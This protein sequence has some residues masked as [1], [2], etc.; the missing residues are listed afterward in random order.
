MPSLLKCPDKLPEELISLVEQFGR[1]WAASSERPKPAPYVLNHWSKLLDEWVNNSELP[2]FVRKSSSVRGSAVEH[3]TGREIVHCDNSPAHWA[4]VLA[5]NGECPSIKDIESWIRSDSI[6]VVMIQR[7]V[8]KPHAKYHCCLPKK[9]N[10]NA[11]GWKV[12]HIRPVG[13]KTRMPI[14]QIPIDKIVE[15]FKFLLSPSNMF[16]VPL[17]WAG[18]AEAQAVVEAIANADEVNSR[19]Q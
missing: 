13:M 19:R 17:V 2:L 4:Y 8:D 18:I 11:H 10:V 3:E 15:R 5:S 14:S 16:V 6:P 1:L 7:T 12:A 9:F